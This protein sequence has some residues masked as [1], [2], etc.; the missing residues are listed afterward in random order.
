MN[1]PKL[2]NSLRPFG[3]DKNHKLYQ[4]QKSQGVLDVRK[5]RKVARSAAHDA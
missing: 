5:Q 2:I 1:F 4:F 3:V